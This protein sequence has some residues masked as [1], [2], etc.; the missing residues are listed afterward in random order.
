[1]WDHRQGG[2]VINDDSDDEQAR[3]RNSDPVESHW[4]A[5]SVTNLRAKQNDVLTVFRSVGSTPLS[6]E[7]LVTIYTAM[8]ETGRVAP[9]SISGIR[10]RRSELERKGMIKKSSLRA[11]TPRGRPCGMWELV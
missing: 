4:A 5:D 11:L 10:T 3:A 9:Q 7:L 8:A 1:M 2:Q 6:E